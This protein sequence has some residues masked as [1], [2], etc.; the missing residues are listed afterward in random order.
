MGMYDGPFFAF[1]DEVAN[2]KVAYVDITFDTIDGVNDGSHAN[3]V[4]NFLFEI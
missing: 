2:D 4:D 1:D 3:I